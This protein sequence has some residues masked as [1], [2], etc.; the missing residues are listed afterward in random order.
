MHLTAPTL[1]DVAR[2]WTDATFQRLIRRNEIVSVRGF[3]NANAG[4]SALE[5]VTCVSR[6]T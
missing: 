1:S 2:S 5:T 6:F 3:A 4:K